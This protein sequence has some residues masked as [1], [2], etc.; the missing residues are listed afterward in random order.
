[1]EDRQGYA[2]IGFAGILGAAFLYRLSSYTGDQL[3]EGMRDLLLSTSRVNDLNTTTKID[4]F[5]IDNCWSK[6]HSFN[7]HIPGDGF[8]LYWKDSVIIIFYRQSSNGQDVAYTLYSVKDSMLSWVK[9]QLPVGLGICVNKMISSSA[10]DH[11][12]DELIVVNNNNPY[13]HQRDAVDK[14]ITRYNHNP[15][16]GQVTLISGLPGC[17][18]S[19]TA[20]LLYMEFA[21]RGERPFLVEGFN[22]CN[23]GLSLIKHVLRVVRYQRPL[24]LLLDEIDTAMV[25]SRKEISENAMVCHAKSKADLCDFFDLLNSVPGLITICTTNESIADLENNYPEYC[26]EGRISEKI[27]YKSN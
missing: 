8:H 15:K 26:R 21:N 19:Y 17:G 20:R 6:S 7:S 24:I 27:T 16:A 25:F 3:M 9:S 10:F 23:P 12:L 2:I 4:K 1:M 11:E 13:D 5:V 22:P 18:K 14:I